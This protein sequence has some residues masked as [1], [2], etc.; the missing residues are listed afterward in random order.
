MDNKN[1][2]K[3][4]QKFL[5]R[6]IRINRLYMKFTTE[7]ISKENFYCLIRNAHKIKDLVLFDGVE[8]G[9]QMTMI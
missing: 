3:G 6:D 7:R 2:Q 1:F 4:V 8:V 9:K 5:D